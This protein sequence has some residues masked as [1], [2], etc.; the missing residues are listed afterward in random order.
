MNEPGLRLD[1][2]RRTFTQGKEALHVL[3]GA[4]LTIQPGEIVA[5]VGP[6]GAGKS[7]LLHIAG[8]LERPDSGEVWLA[9]QPC[10]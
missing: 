8:L 7:T 9:G 4:D 2:I 5:L 1:A 6:S 10:G 3:D